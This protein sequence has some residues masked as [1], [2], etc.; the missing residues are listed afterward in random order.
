MERAQRLVCVRVGVHSCHV[1]FHRGD[2]RV[3]TFFYQLFV[4]RGPLWPEGQHNTVHQKNDTHQPL[5]TITANQTQLPH[6]HQPRPG[7]LGARTKQQTKHFEQKP[8][9]REGALIRKAR[10]LCANPEGG[11]VYPTTLHQSSSAKTEEENVLVRNNIDPNS[12]N[13]LTLP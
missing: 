5:P 13:P 1:F 2:P 9:T 4:T 12:A 3:V 8:C 10:P 11:R 6:A 7:T